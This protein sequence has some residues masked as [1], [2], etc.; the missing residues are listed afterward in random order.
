MI[1]VS[2]TA[3]KNRTM[4]DDDYRVVE[5]NNS[6]ERIP[7]DEWCD[8]RMKG[9]REE[10]IS[11]AL[12]GFNVVCMNKLLRQKDGKGRPH[13]TVAF[14]EYEI[15]RYDRKDRDHLVKICYDKGHTENNIM[16]QIVDK[17]N[18]HKKN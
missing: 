2:G 4:K 6:K 10:N 15:L 9:I 18:I 1:S 16:V 17:K 11:A 12:F 13:V 7:S 3:Y 5:S 8:Q 14:D